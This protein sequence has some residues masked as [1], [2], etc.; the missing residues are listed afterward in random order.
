V[1]RDWFGVCVNLCYGKSTIVLHIEFSTPKQEQSTT[2]IDDEYDMCNEE[3]TQPISNRFPQISRQSSTY[4]W[5]D[6]S[7][8]TPS[9]SDRALDLRAMGMTVLLPSRCPDRNC[10]STRV[11]FGARRFLPP[12]SSP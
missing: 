3:K 9:D 7:K 10:G 11:H 1:V 2:G 8:L 5:R 4:R 12:L 6:K